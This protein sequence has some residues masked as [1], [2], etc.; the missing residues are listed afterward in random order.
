MRAILVE[1]EVVLRE[2]LL[3]LLSRLWPELEVVAHAGDGER[4]LE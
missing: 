2:Q 4:A 1:D 3:R